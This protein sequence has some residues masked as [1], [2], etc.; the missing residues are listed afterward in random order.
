[1]LP[2]E[3]LYNCR[4]SFYDCDF[5]WIRPYTFL[6]G[7]RYACGWKTSYF[8]EVYCSERDITFFSLLY[9]SHNKGKLPTHILGL[10]T[11]K[12]NK[13]IKF[14]RILCSGTGKVGNPFKV[15]TYVILVQPY[16]LK[17]INTYVT[18]LQ[19]VY[20]GEGEGL[21]DSRGLVLW[22]AKLQDIHLVYYVC[23]QYL[24]LPKAMH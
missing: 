14:I 6:S 9:F 22:S 10:N 21:R 1:M 20:S 23:V 13:L 11:S 16:N 5:Y 24:Y 18:E 12:Y 4:L 19:K 7:P 17:Y 15:L 3:F 8:S 2:K